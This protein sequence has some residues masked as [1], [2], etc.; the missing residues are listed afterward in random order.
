M[1]GDDAKGRA[2]VFLMATSDCANLLRLHP[3]RRHLPERHGC[4]AMPSPSTA[5][6]TAA[7][8]TNADAVRLKLNLKNLRRHDQTIQEII[9]STSYVVMYKMVEETWVS[10]VRRGDCNEAIERVGARGG[11]EGGAGQ[12]SRGRE[13]MQLAGD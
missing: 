8:I 9:E 6:A 4:I 3:R 12:G 5:A 2:L 1:T 10:R 13:Q 7:S 11:F